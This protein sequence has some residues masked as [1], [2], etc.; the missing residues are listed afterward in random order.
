MWQRSLSAFEVALLYNG[1]AGRAIASQIFDPATLAPTI[2]LDAADAG[3][4]V[5]SG[6]EVLGWADK[7]GNGF[8]VSPVSTT[9][10]RVA[11]NL[12]GLGTVRFDGSPDVLCSPPSPVLSLP[13]AF[14]L[15]VVS[16]NDARRDYNG[17]FSVRASTSVTA[18]LEVYWQQGSSGSG[19]LIYFVDRFLPTQGGLGANNAGPSP[20]SF[21]LAGVTVDAAASQTTL[22]MGGAVIAT[23]GAVRLPSGSD[24]VCV[25]LG[26]G[27]TVTGNALDGDIAELLVFDRALAPEELATL[28][29]WLARKWGL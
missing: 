1:G 2:W 17:V 9:P 25:G 15:L 23:G 22:R 20:G 11:N 21:Y 6:S 29:D 27:T 10:A 8:D 12:N 13:T 7:S 16:R 5:L 14:T 24:R 3:T 18:D 19:N 4:F 28:E 26:F